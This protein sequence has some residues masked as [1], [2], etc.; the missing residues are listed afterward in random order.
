[1]ETK[2]I[3]LP[4]VVSFLLL[5]CPTPK[6]ESIKVSPEKKTLTVEKKSLFSKELRESLY[7]ASSLER[8]AL[9]LLTHNNSIEPTTVFSILSYAFEIESGTKKSSPRG[10][11]CGRFRID[12]SL[13]A[14]KIFKT[15]QKPE[16]LVAVIRP[17]S[18]G[19][20]YN[21]EIKV[22]E[23][24]SVVGISVA[25]TNPD[26]N[27]QL[28]L[29][30]KKLNALSC[31]HW[32]YLISTSDASATE[33]RLKS[34]VF[35]RD[36]SQQLRLQ[37]GFFR[38]LIER[39]K[40]EVNVPLQGKIKLIEKEIEVK[41]D[42]DEKPKTN[43]AIHGEKANE[44][45][46]SSEKSSQEDYEKWIKAEGQSQAEG[47]SEGQSQDQSQG[48]N[49]HGDEVQNQNKVESSE[50]ESDQSNGG[51]PKVPSGRRGR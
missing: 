8:E 6:T 33:I 31:E 50:I 48:E 21:I 7:F 39:K 34:F 26:I 13:D 25:L 19:V 17:S 27:C 36:Q 43:E 1:M 9:R 28:Q 16:T 2:R 35:N 51:V 44:K 41:D 42:F 30:D 49:T 37:G 12:P 11:D 38:D 46:K 15:C 3:F 47:Q 14:L 45:E 24:S 40:I 10:V 29:K 32:A 5:S 18:N 22:K 20:Q 4:L 23:W